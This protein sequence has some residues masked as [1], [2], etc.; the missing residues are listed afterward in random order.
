MKRRCERIQYIDKIEE[1]LPGL[2]QLRW[3][4]PSLLWSVLVI[5]LLDLATIDA[6]ALFWQ[7]VA[8]NLVS[9]V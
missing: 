3:R 9:Q 1:L 6:Q 8:C 7:D 2:K 5:D 4:Q